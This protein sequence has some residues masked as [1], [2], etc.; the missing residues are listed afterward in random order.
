[1]AE[2]VTDALAEGLLRPIRDTLDAAVQRLPSS[3]PLPVTVGAVP[4]F[5]QFRDGWLVLSD[6]LA[7][8]DLHHP[9]EPRCPIPPLDRWRRAAACVLEHVSLQAVADAVSLQPT[10]SWAWI[11]AAIH[12]ADQT[13]PQLGI[14]DLDVATAV[15]TGDLEQYPRAGVAVY[16]AWAAAGEDPWQRARYVL[17]G[18]LISPKEWL[19]IGRWVLDASGASAALAAPI[20][21]VPDADIPLTLGAWRWQPLLIPAHARGGLIDTERAAAVAEPWAVGGSPHRTLGVAAAGGGALIAKSGGP[22]G[23]WVVSS[24]EGFGQVMGARGVTFRFDASGRVEITFADAFVGPLAALAMAEEVGTS[25]VASGK[26]RVDGPQL[27][28]FQDIN[29][30][31]LTMHGRRRDRFALPARGFGFDAL[32]TALGEGAWGWHEQADRLVL[33]GRV[34][35]GSVDI[36][37]RRE[38]STT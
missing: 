36:R 38:R 30:L 10:D 29:A 21:R 37:L 23:T 32:L 26:W 3:R 35:G 20:P 14:A 18:G 7:G 5:S 4:G 24:A 27:L 17:R 9:H 1:M 13:A 22:V 6:A 25:G 12:M 34:L 28:A 15:Q 8:P 33:R 16:R 2:I 31:G 19:E 11:G